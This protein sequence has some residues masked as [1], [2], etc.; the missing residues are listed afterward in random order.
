[1]KECIAC[2]ETKPLADFY[3]HPSMA[4]GCLNKCILCCRAYEAAR[5]ERRTDA[6]LPEQRFD[7]RERREQAASNRDKYREQNPEKYRATTALNNA[8]RA[9]KIARQPCEECGGRAHA[10]HDDYDKPLVVRWL[11]AKH[12]ARHHASQV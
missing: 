6:G 3:A 10:H 9:G 2:F 4:D 5:R 11:C 8:I 7:T 1:M 12:H